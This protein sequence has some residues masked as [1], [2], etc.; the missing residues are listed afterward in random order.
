M[1]LTARRTRSTDM[2][3]RDR[4]DEV[5]GGAGG[6]GFRPSGRQILGGVVAVVLIVFIA[7]N[8]E[9]TEVSFVFFTATMPLWIVLAVTAVLGIGIGMVLG[10][11]RTKARLR[12]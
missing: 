2:M 3:N 8:S 11:R 9:S 5:P 12:A 7:V 1:D 10:T 6:E 4:S